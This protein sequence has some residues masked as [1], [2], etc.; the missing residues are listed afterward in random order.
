MDEQYPMRLMANYSQSTP[1]S[2]GS[3]RSR[4]NSSMY[5]FHEHHQR[6]NPSCAMTEIAGNMKLNRQQVLSS[7][8]FKNNFLNKFFSLID[9]K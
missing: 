9:F 6:H 3:I 1:R 2:R 4:A 8:G 5:A 7:R